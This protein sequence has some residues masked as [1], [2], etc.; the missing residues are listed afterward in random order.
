MIEV[1]YTLLTSIRGGNSLSN[2]RLNSILAILSC[3]EIL[4]EKAASDKS[5]FFPPLI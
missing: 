4:V 1:F 2:N 3:L 5:G